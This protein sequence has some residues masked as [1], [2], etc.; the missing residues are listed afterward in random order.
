MLKK[1]YKLTTN[2]NN[3]QNNPNN[4]K[5]KKRAHRDAIGD[6]PQN[7]YALVPLHH[8]KDV[9]I[10]HLRLPQCSPSNIHTHFWERVEG[11]LRSLVPT[12]GNVLEKLKCAGHH[13]RVGFQL[14]E[15]FWQCNKCYSYR[16]CMTCA[17]KHGIDKRKKNIDLKESDDD[18]TQNLPPLESADHDVADTDL[19]MHND[20][21]E[22]KSAGN[23]FAVEETVKMQVMDLDTDNDSEQDKDAMHVDAADDVDGNNNNI[24]EPEVKENID[25]IND[26]NN[27][28]VSEPEVKENIGAINGNNNNI[29][30][31]EV[32]ENIDATDQTVNE[33]ALRTM[34]QD[35]RVTVPQDPVETMNQDITVTVPLETV[36]TM[37]QD[38]SKA[39]NQDAAENEI[40]TVGTDMKENHQL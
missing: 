14:D 5:T 13:C 2:L 20:G 8:Q 24:S 10:E 18:E 31:P 40:E 30:E 9:K 16:L 11:T 36:E 21:N 4:Q 25:A 39:M 34:N 29:S 1:C 22:N 26:N 12:Y 27:N 28:N 7:N 17:T 32:N 38:A 23:E 19:Q 3:I 6:E 37:N 15:S 35:V 33:D